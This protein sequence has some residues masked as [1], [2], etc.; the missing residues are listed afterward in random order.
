MKPLK[1][2]ACQL[3]S[4]I[5]KQNGA[6]TKASPAPWQTRQPESCGMPSSV[7][8]VSVM[9]AMLSSPTARAGNLPQMV[10]GS[11]T[12][13]S[14][15]VHHANLSA[16]AESMPVVEAFVGS[17]MARPVSLWNRKSC[18]PRSRCF[19]RSRTPRSLRCS[20]S[21]LGSKEAAPFQLAVCSTR[22]FAPTFCS[23]S[24]AS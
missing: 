16:A 8:A 3:K 5:F 22:N 23:I 10:S 11:P 19:A 24:A 20:Q 21:S 13:V 14:S 7:A 1:A 4:Y 18:E 9:A 6:G 15:V 17:V 2:Q 12:V